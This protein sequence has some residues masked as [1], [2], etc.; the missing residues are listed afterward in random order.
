MRKPVFRCKPSPFSKIIAC[1]TIGATRPMNPE[2][3]P[4]VYKR[5][6]KFSRLCLCIHLVNGSRTAEAPNDP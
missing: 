2:D 6:W 4:T 3:P 1:A 5:G